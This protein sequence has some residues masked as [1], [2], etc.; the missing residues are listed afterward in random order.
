MSS[1]PG[2]PVARRPLHFI[3]ILDV[4]GSMAGDKIQALNEAI[5]EAIP[6]MQSVG[7]QNP[8]ADLLV[9]VVKFSSGAQ[10]VVPTPTP[11]E[12]FAWTP[13]GA[14]G[15]TDL[16]AALK[17]VGAELSV[18]KMGERALPPVLVLVSDGQPTDSWETPLADLMALPWG[19]R[20]V[21]VSIGIGQDIDEDVLQRFNG[22]PEVP[23]LHANNP[24]QLVQRIKWAST[25]VVQASMA[26]A[27][28]AK[29]AMGGN[30]PIPTPP[31]VIGGNSS[32]VW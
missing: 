2:G 11:V 17:I 1:M 24:E 14:S 9:R 10:W 32:D 4:S 22:H 25:A 5:S 3:F 19:K 16:G 15:V 26:P 28:Q 21:R 23:V 8:F 12:S 6:H 18:E 29:G 31:A 13:V 7:M 20:A 30:V 27:S